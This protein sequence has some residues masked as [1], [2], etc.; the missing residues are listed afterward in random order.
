[1]TPYEFATKWGQANLSESAGSQEHFIDICRLIGET[2][3]AEPD[4]NGDFFTF[5][6]FPLPHPTPEQRVDISE[7]AKHLDTLREGSLNPSSDD[8]SPSELKQLTLTNLYNNRPSWLRLAHER[9]DEA[10]S[11]AYGWPADLPDGEII[12]RLLELNLEREAVG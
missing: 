4:P 7:A 10:V 8:V 9:L 5:E 2:T 6:T 1:M 3:T 12:A 11:A